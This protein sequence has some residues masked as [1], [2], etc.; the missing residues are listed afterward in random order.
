[1]N[2]EENLLAR[3]SLRIVVAEG[4]DVSP[5]PES[6]FPDTLVRA[7]AD[8]LSPDRLVRL[9]LPAARLALAGARN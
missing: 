7:L 6:H 1:M 9:E 2:P 3:G 4:A 8:G 5:D